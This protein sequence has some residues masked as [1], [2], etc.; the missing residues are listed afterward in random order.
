MMQL[1]YH[2]THCAPRYFPLST[3]HT[4]DSMLKLYTAAFKAAHRNALERVDSF[5]TEVN[6]LEY[7]AKQSWLCPSLKEMLLPLLSMS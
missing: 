3:H 6:V 7:Q 5:V 4:M 1:S 2:L